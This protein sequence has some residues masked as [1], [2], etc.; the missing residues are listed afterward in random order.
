MPEWFPSHPV[1]VVN[2]IQR[3]HATMFTYGSASRPLLLMTSPGC[4]L[5]FRQ[6][7]SCLRE[8]SGVRSSA[9]EAHVAS[10]SARLWEAT[11]APHRHEDVLAEHPANVCHRPLDDRERGGDGHRRHLRRATIG[12]VKGQAL[13]KIRRVVASD[14]RVKALRQGSKSDLVSG[15]HLSAIASMRHVGRIALL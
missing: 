5:L 3:R 14:I 9:D 11:Q 1:T 8:D 15:I 13:Y 4:A 7:C 6:I 12:R 10:R 2:P